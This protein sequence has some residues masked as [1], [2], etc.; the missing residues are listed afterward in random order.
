MRPVISAAPCRSFV[1][2][3]VIAALALTAF[4]LL[5]ATAGTRTVYGYSWLASL[6]TALTLTI[7]GAIFCLLEDVPLDLYL[8][9][10]FIVWIVMFLPFKLPKGSGDG[11]DHSTYID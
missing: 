1:T 10:A 3:D 4:A 9:I 5:V 11:H 8:L 2:I 7:M 6:T